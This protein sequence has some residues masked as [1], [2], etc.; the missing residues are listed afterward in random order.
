MS[1]FSFIVIVIILF[2]NFF[3]SDKLLK[4]EYD[5]YY[6]QWV[7]DGKRIGFLWRPKNETSMKFSY[8]L[9]EKIYRTPD[10]LKSD[11]Y[12]MILLYL[13]RIFGF[14]LIISAIYVFIMIM[15]YGKHGGLP[16]KWR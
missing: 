9:S 3:I 13:Y 6:D 16:V 8:L 5:K 12:G 10:W 15:L 7:K 4:Y 14:I 11:I 2:M 1:V